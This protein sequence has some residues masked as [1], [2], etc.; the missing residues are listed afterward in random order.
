[1]ARDFMTDEIDGIVVDDPDACTFL[2]PA[3]VKRG[4][5]SVGISTAGTSP[6]A[7]VWL[8]HQISNLIP[9]GFDEILTFLEELRP[10][11][12]ARFP[13]EQTRSALFASLFQDCLQVGRPLT[14]AELEDLL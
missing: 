5:L 11:I 6:T 4:D 2:F 9:A 1:M 10:R 7:A 12:K 13:D 8:K 14:E 3:L